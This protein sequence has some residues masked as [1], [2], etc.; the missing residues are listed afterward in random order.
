MY[1]IIS[2]NITKILI[3]TVLFGAF[4]FSFTQIEKYFY[5]RAAENSESSLSL[6]TASLR[7][8]LNRYDA[9]PRLISEYSFIKTSLLKTENAAFI[10]KA[11]RFLKSLAENVKASD[12]YIMNSQGLT[13][14]ASNYNGPIPFIGRNF[15]YRPYFIDAM[16]GR[17]GRYFALGS[18]SLKRGYYFSAPVKVSDNIIGVAVVKISIDEIEKNWRGNNTEIIVT[19]EHGIIFMSS[20]PIWLFNSLTNLPQKLLKELDET[21]RYPI[22]QVRPLKIN[23]QEKLDKDTNILTIRTGNSVKSYISRSTRMNEAGW[24]VHTF[25]STKPAMIQSYLIA[26][27]LLLFILLLLLLLAFIVQRRKALLDRIQSQR[28]AQGQLEKNVRNRTA[29]LNAA[30]EKLTTEIEERILAE[31]QLRHTQQDLIQA[32]KLAAL[33]QMSAALSHEFNQPLSAMRSYTDNAETFL[34]RRQIKDALDNIGRISELIGRMTAIS[35]HLRNFARKPEEQFGAVP[36]AAVLNDAIVIMSGKIKNNSAQIDLKLPKEPVFILG[37]QV[38]LQQVIVNLISNALDATNEMPSR[39]IE[40]SAKR[41]KVDKKTWITISVRDFGKGF[42]EDVLDRIFDPFFST[43]VDTKGLGLGLSIS[44]N[45]I[46]DFGGQLS[47]HNH[48][49]GG[50]VIVI[51]LLEA[52]MKVGAA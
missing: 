12:I 20:R 43:K 48:P 21:K 15:R 5:F 10:P 28:K 33:G 40:I 50:A 36:L 44:Y 13:I 26:F 16:N 38:R 22:D 41:E 18:T 49:E 52:N 42:K 8:E 31:K 27:L 11:N 23:T 47:A 32:G 45:I 19:D 4:V 1:N 14:A 51:N 17:M 25:T 39:K 46:K 7:G 37:G 24:T 9:L 34:E 2:K 3:G 35:K 30:N 29:D 6:I